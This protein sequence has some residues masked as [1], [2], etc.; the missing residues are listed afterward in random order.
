MSDHKQALLEER[1]QVA[2]LRQTVSELSNQN[3]RYET[4]LKQKAHF[5]QAQLQQLNDS[6]ALMKQEFEA[7]AQ[8]ILE[9]KEKRFQAQSQQS[10]DALLKPMKSE[11]KSFKDRVEKMHQVDSDQRVQLRTELQSLQSLNKE[12]THQA[13]RLTLAL[14]GQKKMQGNWGELMLENV[15][16]SSG[17]RQGKDYKREVSIETE[18]GRQRPDVVV[19]L[20]QQKHLVID[21]KTSLMAYTRFVNSEDPLERAQ[22]IKDHVLAMQDRIKELADKRYYKLNGLNSPEVVIMFVPIES[23]YVEALKNNETLFQQAIEQQVLVATPTTLLT[24]LNIVRQLWRFEDQS[25]HSA[26]LA[27]R[28]EKVYTK[29]TSFL[30]TM[31]DI[32]RKIDGA[33]VSYDRAIGQL[34]SGK[35]NLIKQASEFK[36]LGVSVQKELPQ[37]LVDRAGLELESPDDQPESDQR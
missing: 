2:I 37:E 22:A 14:Q 11:L 7:L 30:T 19:Y 28:A 33:K 21:A 15:L 17:L 16:E 26:Q 34:Y 5:F 1:E 9:A 3:V 18:E 25:K 12:I 24:A 20:P 13:E 4:E 32:G 36:D 29:L 6:R 27:D 8:E 10:L 23:A 31:Q 35:G